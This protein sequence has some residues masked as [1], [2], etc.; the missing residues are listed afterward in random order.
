MNN[1]VFRETRKEQANM[2]MKDLLAAMKAGD[3]KEFGK[4]LENE[5]LSL[6]AMMMTSSPSYVL[7]EPNSLNVITRI[8][9]FREA[10]GLDLYFTIDA[11]PNMHLI[12]PKS[13]EK[14]VKSFIEKELSVF[15]ERVIHDEIGIGIKEEA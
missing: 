6:H 9:K 8:K 13:I 3:F 7:L 5:A 14:E 12:Y 11:G 15:S 1:H 2:N 4:I 10:Y